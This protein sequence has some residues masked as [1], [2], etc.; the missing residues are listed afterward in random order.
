MKCLLIPV[1]ACLA[2]TSTARSLSAC[3][4]SGMSAASAQRLANAI[5]SGRVIRIE[6]RPDSI[7]PPS[8]TARA[9][10]PDALVTLR[11]IRWWK[12]GSAPTAQ[13]YTISSSSACGYP[14]EVGDIYL[15]YT[16]TNADGD[17]QTGLCRRTAL[18]NDAG[19]DLAL[20]GPGERPRPGGPTTPSPRAVAP[21]MRRST[22]VVLAIGAALVGMILGFATGRASADGRRSS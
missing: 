6:L 7:R 14:F 5:Y 10:Q 4:C 22:F 13:V 17:P 18:L 11:V 21:A 2:L 12:G 16:Y 20:L 3:T 15:V 19:E 1:L 9:Y 8:D